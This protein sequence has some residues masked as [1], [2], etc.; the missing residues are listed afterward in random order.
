M[1]C[2]DTPIYRSQRCCYSI[3]VLSIAMKIIQL[4]EWNIMFFWVHLLLIS[5]NGVNRMYYTWNTQ[6]TKSEAFSHC[7]FVIHE[8]EGSNVWVKYVCRCSSLITIDQPCHDHILEASPSL[9][10]PKPWP[11]VSG[12]S[13]CVTNHTPNFPKHTKD[14]G[15]GE[16]TPTRL[17]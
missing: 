13:A 6:Q 8:S 16:D 7:I 5:Q 11:T 1:Q 9:K 2:N 10:P 14:V 15:T 4:N 17:D 3:L 12:F